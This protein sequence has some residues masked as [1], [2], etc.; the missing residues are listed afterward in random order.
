MKPASFWIIRLALTVQFLGVLSVPALVDASEAP[1]A[2]WL[3]EWVNAASEPAP[4]EQRASLGE[5]PAE[6]NGRTIGVLRMRDN[7]LTFTEQ[8]GQANWDLDLAAVKRV[9]SVQGGRALMIESLTGDRYIVRIIDANFAPGNPK[10]A[11]A[12]LERA[13]EA[14]AAANR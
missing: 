4:S 9:Q 7:K 14:L 11:Q 12:T 1:R 5:G 8:I 13:I 2:T 3:A 10:R 6:S